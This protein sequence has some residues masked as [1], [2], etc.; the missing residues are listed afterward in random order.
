MPNLKIHI[1]QSLLE[2]VEGPIAALLAPL[3]GLLCQSLAVTPAACQLA[4]IAVRGLPDQPLVNVELAILPRPE[5][6]REKVTA[7][8]A[9]IQAMVAEAAGT[10][11]AVRCSQLDP[12]TYV[13]LK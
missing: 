2:Q 3:R 6:T 11:V 12:A 5:R 13:A 10:H 8:C 4:V 7:T 9:A 1:D